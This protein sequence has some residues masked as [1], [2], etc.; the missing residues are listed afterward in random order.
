MRGKILARRGEIDPSGNDLAV[1]FEAHQ[2][3]DVRNLMGLRFI[4]HI[5]IIYL[6][7]GY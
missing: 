6:A 7:F 3:K 2:R 1:W 4:C 5:T